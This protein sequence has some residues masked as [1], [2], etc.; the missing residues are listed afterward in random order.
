MAL[1]CPDV[2]AEAVVPSHSVAPIQVQPCLSHHGGAGVG[3]ITLGWESWWGLLVWAHPEWPHLHLV[4]YHL[5]LT[6]S[7]SGIYCSLSN[8]W[9]AHLELVRI[10]RDIG[11]QLNLA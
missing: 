11:M 3:E 7:F 8:P 10:V 5:L 9:R 1:P 6:S 4:F 2:E